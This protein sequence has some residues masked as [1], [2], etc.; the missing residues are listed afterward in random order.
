MG[1]PRIQSAGRGKGLVEPVAVAAST[2]VTHN[3][4]IGQRRTSLRLEP[5]LWAALDEICQREGMT[6]HEICTTIDRR[7][8]TS[9]LTA[10]VRVYVVNYYRAA[11]TEEGHA[12]IG[13]GPILRPGSQLARS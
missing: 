5:A 10:A 9:T 12:S 2:L 7:R 11:A 3:V 1:K 8:R 6:R 13:H 4:R